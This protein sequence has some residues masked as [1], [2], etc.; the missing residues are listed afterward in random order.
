VKGYRSI[1]SWYLLRER[2]AKRMATDGF[3]SLII[4]RILLMVAS[5]IWQPTMMAASSPGPR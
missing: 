5:S 4:E 1:V 2:V 3:G